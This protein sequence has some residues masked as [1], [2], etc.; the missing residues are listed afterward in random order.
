MKR[1]VDTVVAVIKETPESVIECENAKALGG[2]THQA[3]RS[4]TSGDCQTLSSWI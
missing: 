3:T 2:N 1:R 4:E